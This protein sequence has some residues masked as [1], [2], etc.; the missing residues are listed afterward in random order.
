LAPGA[1]GPRI[2][3]GL[4]AAAWVAVVARV[5]RWERIRSIM[6]RSAMNATIR[7]ATYLLQLAEYQA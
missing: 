6:D 1:D 5:L 4:R 3:E 2:E 7:M